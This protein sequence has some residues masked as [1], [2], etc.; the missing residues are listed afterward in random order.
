MRKVLHLIK[1]GLIALTV[2][3]GLAVPLNLPVAAHAQVP[4]ESKDAA[5]AGLGAA[6]GQGCDESAGR[7][8][9][10]LLATVINILSWIVGILA[11]IMIIIG[12]LKY[13]TS[14]G[15]SNSISSAKSTIIYALIGVAVAALAQV[16]VRTV[17]AQVSPERAARER[18]SQACREA[19][20]PSEWDTC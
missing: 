7:S 3:A 17:L 6:S 4:Q 8:L 12:G 15:D 10:G 9:R 19:L 14:N 13:I 20:P 16:L 1:N 2:L 5:C 11:V 18:Q